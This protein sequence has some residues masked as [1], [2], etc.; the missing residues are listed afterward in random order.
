MYSDHSVVS[1]TMQNAVLE[2]KKKK[3]VRLNIGFEKQQNQM[4]K[5]MSF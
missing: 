2:M 5:L 1:F 4:V 3:L